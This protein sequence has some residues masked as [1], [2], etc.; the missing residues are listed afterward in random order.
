MSYKDE[1]CK[2]KE[3]T[4]DNCWTQATVCYDKFIN[5]ITLHR[6]DGKLDEWNASEVPICKYLKKVSFS[7]GNNN[8][9]LV[10][11]SGTRDGYKPIDTIKF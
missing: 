9:C 7:N 11:I 4:R 5:G 6:K 10:S 3:V 8:G 2:H 1:K